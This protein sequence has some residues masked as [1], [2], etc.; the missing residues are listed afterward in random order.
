MAAATPEGIAAR[1]IQLRTVYQSARFER[2]PS[3]EEIC[4]GTKIS[5]STLR[6]YESGKSIPGGLAVVELCYLYECTADWL[7]GIPPVRQR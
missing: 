4:E 6:D 5:A 7:L 2:A 1:L 3:P